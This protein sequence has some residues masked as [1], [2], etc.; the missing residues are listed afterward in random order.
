MET[1]RIEEESLIALADN[2]RV[3]NGTEDK[4]TPNDM[5]FT[6]ESMPKNS[7]NDLTVSGATVTVPAGYY[8]NEATKS[9][10]VSIQET[11]NIHID[12]NGLITVTTQQTA[13]YVYAET[14]NT[15]YQLVVEPAKTI[16]PTAASQVAIYAGRYAGRDITVAGDSNLVAE[17]IKSGVIIFGVTGTY[18]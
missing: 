6:L 14:K 18:N 15:T 12:T 17:N 4:I 3:L 16:V 10:P 5:T 8:A 7:S 13:G 2:I 1:Y 9:I 11:P